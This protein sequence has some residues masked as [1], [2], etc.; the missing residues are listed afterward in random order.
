M[1]I[2]TDRKSVEACIDWAYRQGY[3]YGQGAAEAYARLNGLVIVK[4]DLG[5]WGD[6]LRFTK[7]DAGDRS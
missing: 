2:E 5:L 4:E 6:A 7:Q 3:S 1:T